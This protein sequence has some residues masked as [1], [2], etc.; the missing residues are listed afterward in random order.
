MAYYFSCSVDI[1]YVSS[2]W[3]I[4]SICYSHLMIQQKVISSHRKFLAFMRKKYWPIFSYKFY[5]WNCNFIFYLRASHI[6]RTTARRMPCV[7][8][9][10]GRRNERLTGVFFMYNI[11]LLNACSFP[12]ISFSLSHRKHMRGMQNYVSRNLYCLLTQIFLTH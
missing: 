4:A 5:L 2:K 9:L 10:L 12:I 8:F 7:Y 1:L 3:L 6:F 11:A